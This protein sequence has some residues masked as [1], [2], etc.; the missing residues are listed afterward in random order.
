MAARARV[1]EDGWLHIKGRVVAP[2]GSARVEVEARDQVLLGDRGRQ[3]ASDLGFRLASE[4]LS[5]GAAKLL[6]GAID[7]TGQV[8][9]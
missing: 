2:D 6:I 1:S 3:A 5:Q 4:A 9:P 8:G 7:L